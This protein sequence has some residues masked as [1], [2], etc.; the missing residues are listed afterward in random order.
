MKKSKQLSKK[1]PAHRRTWVDLEQAKENQFQLFAFHLQLLHFAACLHR[2][3]WTEILKDKGAFYI[4]PVNQD[5]KLITL[6]LN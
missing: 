2:N 1:V 6:A 3:S 4:G 5:D